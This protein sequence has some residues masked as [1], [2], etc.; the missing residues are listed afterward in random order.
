[1]DISPKP[2]LMPV[3]DEHGSRRLAT[4]TQAGST[5]GVFW[6][7]GFNSDM[8]ST[9][10]TGLAEWATANGVAL[11]RFDYS[12]HGQSD[13]K[14]PDGSISQWLADT[15]AVFDRLTEGPQVVIGSSM[16]GYLAMLLLR[17]LKARGNLADRV[18][19]L[20]LIA[21]AWDMTEELMWAQFP[22]DIRRTIETDGV[23]M[24]PSAYGDPYPIT[25]KLI[26]DGRLHRFAGETWQPGVPVRILQGRLDPDVPYDHAAKL[27]DMASDGSDIALIEV[28]DGDHRLSRP[29]D[30][31]LLIRTVETMRGC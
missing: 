21:P 24:R 29:E 14:L 17:T 23:W 28:P 12:G 10:A 4:L 25:R 5:P 31:E 30:I 26:E 2:T 18:K 1:M 13:C 20:I 16:G 6:M 27:M 15:V 9:K 11:T 19:A 8:I 7:Q 3:E 22:D